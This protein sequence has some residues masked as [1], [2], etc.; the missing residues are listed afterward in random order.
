MSPNNGAH[1]NRTK[2]RAGH[3]EYFSMGKNNRIS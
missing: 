1:F 3:Q 2:K